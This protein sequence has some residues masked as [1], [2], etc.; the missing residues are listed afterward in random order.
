MLFGVF[1]LH[2]IYLFSTKHMFVHASTVLHVT[3]MRVLYL[4]MET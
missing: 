4:Q 2:L 1:C 3:S